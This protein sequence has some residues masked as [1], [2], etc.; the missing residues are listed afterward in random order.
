[1]GANLGRG[2][3]CVPKVVSAPAEAADKWDGTGGAELQGEAWCVASSALGPDEAPPTGPGL[4]A[5]A[6]RLRGPETS[7]ASRH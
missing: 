7:K 5:E 6:G 2:V 1:M 3:I 4:Q